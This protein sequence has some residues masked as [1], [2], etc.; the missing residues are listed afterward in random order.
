VWLTVLVAVAAIAAS[1]SKKGQKYDA[2]LLKNGSFEKVGSDGLPEGWKLVLFRGAEGESEVGYGIDTLAVDGERSWSFRA[3][4]G[5]RHWRMLQQE[6]EVSEETTHVRIMGWIQTED[7]EMM[8]GQ[9]AQCNFLLTFYD[10]AH[11]RFQEL[12][13][14]DKRTPL[15]FGTNPWTEE[16]FTYR[17]PKGTRFIAVSCV[18]GMNGRAWFDNVS[19]SVPKP[20]PWETA[21]TKN[22]VFHWLPGHPMPDGSREAQQGIFDFLAG[23]LGLESDVVINYYFY[24]D[25]ATIRQILSIKGFQ[26]VSWDDFEFH[27]IDANDNH[28]VVHFMT[29]GIGRP[30]RSISEGT[31]FWMHDEW[32]GRPL[33]E[34]LKVLVKADK[35]PSL[36]ILFDYNSLVSADP[37]V[38]MPMSA[39]FVK[40]IVERWGTEKL[41]AFYAAVNGMNS[42]DAVAVGFERVYGL[43]LADAEVAWRTWLK[44][45]YGK[46]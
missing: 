42:H 14:A 2:N 35:V 33:E 11:A 1:C 7:A 13:V 26:Y 3:D 44:V 23:K 34:T 21:T 9:F 45:H 31:V 15:R 17:V 41:L 24:P 4:P 8:K 20:V 29:D 18:L 39:A 10:A 30:P 38:T 32:N 46:V 25:T 19:L 36:A 43:P 40:F 37:R 27:S 6:V 16:S 5:T 22:F 28:E 12:R